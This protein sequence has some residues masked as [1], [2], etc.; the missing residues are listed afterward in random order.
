M[1]EQQCEKIGLVVC[2]ISPFLINIHTNNTILMSS[3]IAKLCIFL[4]LFEVQVAVRY[5]LTAPDPNQ[6]P[7][8][9]SFIMLL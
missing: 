6:L 1:I 3:K 4:G 8:S 7:V 9:A 2:F 5:L